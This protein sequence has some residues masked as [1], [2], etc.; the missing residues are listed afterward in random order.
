VGDIHDVKPFVF[1]TDCFVMAAASQPASQLWLK[2]HLYEHCIMNG[3]ISWV[4]L[5]AHFSFVRLFYYCFHS[6]SAVY[7][8]VSF[9]KKI[10][11][12]CVCRDVWTRHLT[13][14]DYRPRERTNNKPVRAG[15]A[16]VMSNG[17]AKK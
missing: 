9:L 16:K 17:S 5:D 11:S 12:G 6:L 3:R 4:T 1:P 15:P 14:A 2:L 8:R 10:C 13:R 7:A